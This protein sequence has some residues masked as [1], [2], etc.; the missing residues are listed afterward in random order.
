MAGDLAAGPGFALTSCVGGGLVTK[1]S[2]LCLT[3]HG[4]MVN[5]LVIAFDDLCGARKRVD[6]QGGPT[7]GG[8]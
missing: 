8:R 7:P 6:P 1:Q 2:Q 3:P 4:F 5:R